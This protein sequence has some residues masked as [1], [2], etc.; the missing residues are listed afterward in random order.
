[1][2]IANKLTILRILLIPFFVLCFFTENFVIALIIFILASVTDFLDGFLARKYNMCTDFGAFL[3]PVADKLLVM[4]ALYLFS[5]NSVFP[6]YCF[7]IMFCRDLLVDSLRMVSS[8]KGI[9][10]KANIF[11]KLKTVLQMICIIILF[12][13]VI[14]VNVLWPFTNLLTQIFIYASTIVSALSGII[15]LYEG[16]SVISEVK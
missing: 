4:S 9:T 3:D 6:W 11:G 10:I 7:L 14:L 13:N 1:M 2:N 12:M 15:Y 16:R 8:R 5:L